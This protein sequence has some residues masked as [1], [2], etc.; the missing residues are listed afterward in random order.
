MQR[1]KSKKKESMKNSTCHHLRCHH[2]YLVSIANCI[3]HVKINVV[4]LAVDFARLCFPDLLGC[5]LANEAL[6]WQNR[7]KL[8][9]T[10]I[11]NGQGSEI[12]NFYNF[13]L[14][15]IFTGKKVSREKRSICCCK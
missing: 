2:I 4:V 15:C 14:G 3:E 6:S 7:C 10:T 1:S 9:E 11:F 8:S 5:E 13:K 12:I